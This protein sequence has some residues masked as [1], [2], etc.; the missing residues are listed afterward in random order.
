MVAN[1]AGVVGENDVFNGLGL[2]GLSANG[3][4]LAGMG[5][6]VGVS[7]TAT[8]PT[9]IA[10]YARDSSSIGA[11]SAYDDDSSS[12]NSALFGETKGGYGVYGYSLGASGVGVLGQGNI[13][14]VQATL[15]GT[16]GDGF[17]DNINSSEA[18]PPAPGEQRRQRGLRRRQH[19]TAFRRA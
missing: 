11:L 1:A 6:T 8:A 16:F 15:N 18:T 13:I 4:G 2:L 3:L 12:S 14:G 9:G 10:L 7:A 17:S 5:S 19:S